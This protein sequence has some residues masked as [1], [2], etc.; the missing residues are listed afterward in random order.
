MACCYCF[1]NWLARRTEP[2]FVVFANVDSL[3]TPLIDNFRLPTDATEGGLEGKR[4][5][6]GFCRSVQAG[7]GTILDQVWWCDWWPGTGKY[8]AYHSLR[9]ERTEFYKTL[10]FHFKEHWLIHLWPVYL[11]I[12]TFPIWM[13]SCGINDVLYLITLVL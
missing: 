8:L 9:Y 10:S 7:P 1:N 3:N 12:L 6:I 4:Y 11:Y 5:T 2:W 13:E